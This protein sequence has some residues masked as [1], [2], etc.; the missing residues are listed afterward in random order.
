VID[1]GRGENKAS[2]ETIREM[3]GA[4]HFVDVV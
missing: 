4:K 2:E 1:F 3:R